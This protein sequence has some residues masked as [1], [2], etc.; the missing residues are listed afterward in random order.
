MVNNDDSERYYSLGDDMTEDG[1]VPAVNQ[2]GDPDVPPT[3]R[4]KAK[5]C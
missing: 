4:R 5:V 2:D 3:N 1:Q